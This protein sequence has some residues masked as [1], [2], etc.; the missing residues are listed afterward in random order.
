MSLIG[1]NDL[2]RNS[3]INKNDIKKINSVFKA[4][5]VKSVLLDF[6]NI[7]FPLI[8][9]LS[10]ICVGLAIVTRVFYVV[11]GILAENSSVYFVMQSRYSD[12]A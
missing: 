9:I 7:K 11:F 3:Q 5:V 1:F 12:L 8:F 4:L 2:T 10:L 6:K